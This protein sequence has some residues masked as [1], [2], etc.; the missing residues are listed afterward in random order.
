M[1]HGHHHHRYVAPRGGNGPVIAVM[2]VFVLGIAGAMAWML[3]GG[4]A[5]KGAH[6]GST[7]AQGGSPAPPPTVPAT[8]TT[9]PATPGT[10]TVAGVDQELSLIHI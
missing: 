9:P 1:T 3:T 7:A 10:R 8:A 5:P 6:P 4:F 2:L